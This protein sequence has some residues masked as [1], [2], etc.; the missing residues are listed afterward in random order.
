MSARAGEMVIARVIAAYERTGLRPASG[1]RFVASDRNGA[2]FACGVGA[3]AIDECQADDDDAIVDAAY[4]TSPFGA[5]RTHC[6]EFGFDDAVD[7]N[8]HSHVTDGCPGCGRDRCSY[9]EAGAAAAV[10]MGIA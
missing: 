1:D 4:E 8:I 6:V 10:A 5:K 2:G 3:V 7:A 9:Y